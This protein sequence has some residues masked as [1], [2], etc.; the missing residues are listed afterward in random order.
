MIWLQKS[1]GYYEATCNGW[2]V[3]KILVASYPRVKFKYVAERGNES[4]TGS[5]ELIQKVVSNTKQLELF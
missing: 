5:Y 4:F 3:K 1:Q 2:T